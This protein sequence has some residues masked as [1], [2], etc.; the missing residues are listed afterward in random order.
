MARGPGSSGELALRIY[1]PLYLSLC[2]GVDWRGGHADGSGEG[3]VTKTDGRG[4]A[5]VKWDNGNYGYYRM[6]ASSRYE[7]KPV[8]ASRVDGSK[9]GGQ[10]EEEEV[11]E[12]TDSET[13]YGL[14][15][16]NVSAASTDLATPD[17]S[18]VTTVPNETFSSPTNEYVQS[19]SSVIPLSRAT[20][21]C[22]QP[23]PSNRAPPTKLCDICGGVWTPNT[24]SS[25][26]CVSCTGKL[27]RGEIT[28]KGGD[29]AKYDRIAFIQI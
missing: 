28:V 12:E 10:E 29:L 22:D 25:S 3:T 6:G 15:E 24:L 17:N 27:W 18:Y 7:I 13:E 4:M 11:E 9:L 19:D 20:T 26:M 5:A 16:A 2:R 21:N 14:K 8:P 23:E 1:C